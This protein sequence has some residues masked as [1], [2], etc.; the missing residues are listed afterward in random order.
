[1]PVGRPADRV[2]ARTHAAYQSQASGASFVASR[3]EKDTIHAV[4]SNAGA[5]SS[6]SAGTSLPE[7]FARAQ[8]ESYRNDERHDECENDGCGEAAAHD[9]QSRAQSDTFHGTTVRWKR[10]RFT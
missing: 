4:R 5:G 7:R 8:F 2:C 10:G 9:R 3:K 1:M 6:G